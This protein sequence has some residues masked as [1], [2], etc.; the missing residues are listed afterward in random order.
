MRLTFTGVDEHTDLDALAALW[1]QYP[2]VEIAVLAGTHTTNGPASARTD[3]NPRFPS[4]TTI[5]AFMGLAK[6]LGRQSA[7]HLCGCYS[8]EVNGGSFQNARVLTQGFSRVQVNAREKDYE[9]MSIQ[10][11]ADKLGDD[12]EIIIQ[13]RETP[14]RVFEHPKISRLFDKSGGRG[15]ANFL[16]WSPPPDE[17]GHMGYAGGINPDNVEQALERATAMATRTWLDM[18]SGV[19][20]DNRFDLAKVKRVC[21][22]VWPDKRDVSPGANEDSAEGLNMARAS[23]FGI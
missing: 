2:L 20:T 15:I 18:E 19:R 21:A 7:I 6:G 22:T 5:S 12:Y 1:R 8:R 10:E 17:S 3:P 14:T 16:E 13:T 23:V 9:M 11:F 4:R